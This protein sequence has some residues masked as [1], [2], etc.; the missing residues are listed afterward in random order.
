M[1]IFI[2]VYIMDFMDLKLHLWLISKKFKK[3]LKK[4]QKNKVEKYI[5]V[6]VWMVGLIKT[7][8]MDLLTMGDRKEEEEEVVPKNI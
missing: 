4:K 5:P 1:Y 3:N 2:E 7:S 6:I 8:T